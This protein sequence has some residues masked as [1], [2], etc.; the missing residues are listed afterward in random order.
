MITTV[1]ATHA[2][3]RKIMFDYEDEYLYEDEEEIVTKAEKREQK[4]HKKQYGPIR[5]LEG[6]YRPATF[7]NKPK[8]PRNRPVDGPTGAR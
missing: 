1:C 6:E 5:H 2:G 4:K 3:K 8:R 7:K